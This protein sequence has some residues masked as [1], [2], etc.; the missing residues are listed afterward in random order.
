MKCK[1][2]Y[3]FILV[4]FLIVGALTFDHVIVRAQEA[5]D[6]N[7]GC[8]DSDH[9][10]NYYESGEASDFLLTTPTHDYCT[11]NGREVEKCIPEEGDENCGI[12]EKYCTNIERVSGGYLSG[13]IGRAHV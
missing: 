12:A 2:K 3:F 8:Y 4:M 9:G 5:A 13:E 10:K 1:Y 7:Q 6:Q 11:Q